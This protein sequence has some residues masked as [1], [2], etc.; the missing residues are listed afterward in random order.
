MCRPQCSPCISYIFGILPKCMANPSSA[1]QF[2]WWRCAYL[3][4]RWPFKMLLASRCIRGVNFE[5]GYKLVYILW[6]PLYNTGHMNKGINKILAFKVNAFTN[7]F[8]LLIRRS[9]WGVWC[10]WSVSCL[11][12]L[13]Y[14]KVTDGNL[15]VVI[16]NEDHL[17]RIS[18]LV[19]SFKVG[20][21]HTQVKAWMVSRKVISQTP[22]KL[23]SAAYCCWFYKAIAFTYVIDPFFTTSFV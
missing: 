12:L 11:E 1:S 22:L 10:A 8:R 20:K 14:A 19:F 2:W 23:V 9:K 18:N 3:V 15:N 21:C 17:N 13:W 5:K 6:H 4:Q 7:Y 16:Y